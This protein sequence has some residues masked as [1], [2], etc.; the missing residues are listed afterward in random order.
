M[1]PLVKTI[2][3]SINMACLLVSLAFPNNVTL[4]TIIPPLMTSCTW[5][6]ETARQHKKTKRW[7]TVLLAIASCF[8][9]I[10][11]ALGLTCEIQGLGPEY[12]I[13]F[14]KQVAFFGNVKFSY[15]IAAGLIV[16]L[17]L[18]ISISDIYT[19]YSES[20]EEN[21]QNFNAMLSN[22]LKRCKS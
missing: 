15:H 11:I 9:V 6:L 10:C 2:V 7:L 16:F 18:A 3:A 5:I 13:V 12:Y 21:N 14:R 8:G 20:K 22:K 4:L 19:S 1:G 17:F